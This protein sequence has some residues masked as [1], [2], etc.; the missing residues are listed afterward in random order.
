ME[1]IKNIYINHRIRLLKYKTQYKQRSVE[2]YL[3]RKKLITASEASSCLVKTKGVMN[4]Y[5]KSYNQKLMKKDN[6]DTSCN[7][8]M[9]INDFYLKKCGFVPFK[10]NIATRHGQKFEDVASNI[11][12]LLFQTKVLEFGLLKHDTLHWLGASPDG[13]TEKGVMLEIKCPYRRKITGIAPFYYWV[14]VQLQLEVCD[15]DYCDFL[16]CSL[17]QSALQYT[18]LNHFMKIQTSGVL[19]EDIFDKFG[20]D[21][22]KFPDSFFLKKGV[23]IMQRV[24]RSNFEA[25][26]YDND[27][28]YYY[29]SFEISED[30]LLLLEWVHK[31]TKEIRSALTIQRAWKNKN[32]NYFIRPV[33]WYLKD[34]H[35]SRIKRNKEWFKKA[36]PFLFNAYNEMKL[37]QKENGEKLNKGKLLEEEEEDKFE[38]LSHICF[39]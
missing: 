10:G 31:K 28:I 27:Y 19:I 39:F 35:V 18:T 22:K 38:S 6:L 21:K 11:Y 20:E 37:H 3:Q 17:D 14:Q 36:K 5:L 7:P 13:I 25:K 9:K 24:V 16:E 23:F 2:W 33:F 32:K 29:P 15:L 30:I 8:Y 34:I 1:K 4:P 12:S 26:D